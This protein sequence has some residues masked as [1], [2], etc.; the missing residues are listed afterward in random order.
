MR[1]QNKLKITYKKI[2][3]E[4]SPDVPIELSFN[5]AYEFIEG[6][7]CRKKA[8]KCHVV[9]TQF[10]LLQNFQDS[11][12]KSMILVSGAAKTND[13]KM[14][15]NLK[16]TVDV[17]DPVKD[18]IYEIDTDSTYNIQ[19]SNNQ[20]RVLVHCAMGMSRSATMVIVYLMRKFNIGWQ[21]AFDIVK[22]R[23]DV[24][25][26]NEGF[27]SKLKEYDQKLLSVTRK[28]LVR[29]RSIS[30]EIAEE[31]EEILSQDSD[32]EKVESSTSSEDL[33]ERKYSVDV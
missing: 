9:S 12:K 7:L 17:D 19:N 33:M 10:D 6:A 32:D 18:K 28:S 27:I 23:R 24:I 11:R 22:L 30:T 16:C 3:I 2:G 26:P 14:D 29:D 15:L 5:L 25:D 4:D 1:S 31:N 20:N 8:P 13:I 21:L